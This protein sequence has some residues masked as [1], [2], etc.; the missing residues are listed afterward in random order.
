MGGGF[1]LWSLASMAAEGWE[2]LRDW[3]SLSVSFC[4]SFSDS[5][6]SPFLKFPESRNFD[7]AEILTRFLSGYHLSC[8]ER[9]APT[10]LQGGHKPARRTMPPRVCPYGL[11]APRAPP[12]VDSTSQNSHIFQKN[13]RKFLSRLD[14]V[15]YGFSMKQK[16]CN[17]Q[18]LALGTGSI[19]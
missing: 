13:L 2:P 7:W 4:F 6:L 17:K 16:I 8:I 9:R 15:W 19:S 11:W 3:I 10:A 1:T 5:G 14:F 12:S 18:E